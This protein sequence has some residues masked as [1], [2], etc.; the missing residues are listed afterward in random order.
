MMPI[1]STR[2]STI[3]GEDHLSPWQMPG[4]TRL[5]VGDGPFCPT[6]PNLVRATGRVVTGQV[7]Q[8]IDLTDY[9]EW[10]CGERKTWVFAKP[11]GTAEYEYNSYRASG[12]VGITKVCM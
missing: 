10:R 11:E 1:N 7:E 12:Q 4:T 3:S 6:A 9:P 2:V 5:L 8:L